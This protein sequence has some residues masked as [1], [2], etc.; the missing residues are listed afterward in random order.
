MKFIT[1]E[2]TKSIISFLTGLLIIFFILYFRLLYKRLPKSLYFTIKDFD[3][4]YYNV[5]IIIFITVMTI[6]SLCFIY[7]SIRILNNKPFQIS[8]NKI[9]LTIIKLYQIISESL[10]AVHCFIVNKIPNGYVLIGNLIMKFYYSPISQYRY[11]T[12]FEYTIRTII[13]FSFLF[14]IFIHFELNYFYNALSL[15][16]FIILLKLWLF[17][18]KDWASISNVE[19]AKNYLNIESKN[20]GTEFEEHTISFKKIYENQN[21]D[22]NYHIEQYRNLVTISEYIQDFHDYE[23]YYNLR[24]RLFY[25]SL[26]LIGCIYI[27]IQNI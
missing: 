25:Y 18:I 11:I 15:I 16:I 20:V 17:N 26:F 1:K 19:L 4:Q 14:D 2:T 9:T 8:Y 13:C 6:I 21:L 24:F 10:Y 12:L 3:N 5:P 22:L 7:I 23:L 27:I